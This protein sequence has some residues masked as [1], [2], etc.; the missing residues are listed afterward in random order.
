MYEYLLY[1]GFIG[2]YMYIHIIYFITNHSQPTVKPSLP[3][4]AFVRLFNS[5]YLYRKLITQISLKLKQ[6]LNPFFSYTHAAAANG[7]CF[8][9]PLPRRCRFR[10]GGFLVLLFP[11][12]TCIRVYTL[13]MCAK[14][15]LSALCALYSFL[16]SFSYLFTVNFSASFGKF[17]T[18]SMS[19][20]TYANNHFHRHYQKVG[21]NR[22]IWFYICR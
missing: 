14:F 22:H 12:H 6:A 3:L 15:T 9:L 19:N 11:L 13:W 20:F 1:V 17:D 5:M 10:C 4:P 16:S 21:T 2:T 7:W 8:L 18:N